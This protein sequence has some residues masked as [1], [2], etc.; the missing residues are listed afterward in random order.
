MPKDMISEL[1][2][3]QMKVSKLKGTLDLIDRKREDMIK[4][5]PKLAA[6]EYRKT[7]KMIDKLAGDGVKAISQLHKATQ[8]LAKLTQLAVKS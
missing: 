2:K 3:A 5:L 4:K 7:I 1:E 6:A 8:D